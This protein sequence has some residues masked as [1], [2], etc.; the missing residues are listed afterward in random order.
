MINKIPQLICCHFNLIDSLMYMFT[1]CILHDGPGL[2]RVHHLSSEI[3]HAKF[4]EYTSNAIHS[5]TVSQGIV[6]DVT[7]L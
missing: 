1:S 4:K 6:T 7:N 3:L 5:T 2:D